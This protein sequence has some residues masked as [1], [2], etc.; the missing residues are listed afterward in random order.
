MKIL[1]AL[2]LFWLLA[3]SPA[4]A[5]FP[6]VEGTAT[7][8]NTSN[9]TSQN[10]NLPA[11]IAAGELLLVCGSIDND[12]GT[13]TWPG[14]SEWTQL[15]NSASGVNLVVGYKIASGSEGTSMTVTTANSQRSAWVAYR[16]STWHGTS[17]PEA[18]TAVTNSNA[19]SVT[20]SWGS[21]DNLWIPCTASDGDAGSTSA[22]TVQTN[23]TDLLEADAGNTTAG[24]TILSSRR[25]LAASSEDPGDYGGTPIA[26]PVSTTIVVRPAGGG[27]TPSTGTRR[28][29]G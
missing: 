18:A 22:I 21:A 26:S 8:T 10:V 28:R 24:A 5:A 23:Y 25:A 13:I 9:G 12:P 11:S 20:P 7:A 16:I 2:L 19:P 3:A 6:V 15:I 1:R 27:A 14:S 17:A 29:H 4:W